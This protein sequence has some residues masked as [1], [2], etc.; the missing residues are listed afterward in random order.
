MLLR[1]IHNFPIALLLLIV[2][3]GTLGVVEAHR[4]IR[5]FEAY[6]QAMNEV[7]ISVP[8]SAP[9]LSQESVDLA[10]EIFAIS[11]PATVDGP[12]LNETLEDRGLTTGGLILPHKEVT[13][14]PTAFT[15]WAV[16]GSTLAHELEVHVAQSFFRIVA[17]DYILNWSMSA[18]RLAGK[19]IPV[20]KP[21]AKESFENDGTWKAEREAYM[22][23][24]R[25]A[26]RFGLTNEELNSI[27]RVMDYYYPARKTRSESS[28]LSASSETGSAAEEESQDVRSSEL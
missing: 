17:T 11:K 26:K 24:I 14:G 3:L 1:T 10:M 21:S 2:G 18:R 16:L 6:S 20:L 4:E 28:Q 15:S 27:W 8:E 23:E 5:A 25:N 22:Y 19:V 9:E 12:T 13:V 7:E